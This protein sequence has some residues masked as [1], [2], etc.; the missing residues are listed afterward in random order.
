MLIALYNS[1]LY[2]TDANVNSLCRE[3]SREIFTPRLIL[4]LTPPPVTGDETRPGRAPAPLLASTAMAGGAG[5]MVDGIKLHNFMVAL[6]KVMA[7]AIAQDDP[8]AGTRDAAYEPGGARHVRFLDASKSTQGRR[9]DRVTK[10]FDRA[11]RAIGKKDYSAAVGTGVANA[12][13]RKGHGALEERYLGLET[14]AF[15][16]ALLRDEGARKKL[17]AAIAEVERSADHVNE[18]VI[19]KRKVNSTY[20]MIDVYRDLF[21]VKHPSRG[22]MLAETKRLVAYLYSEVMTA[23]PEWLDEDQLDNARETTTRAAMADADQRAK[24]ERGDRLY[25]AFSSDVKDECLAE[26]ARR[27]QSFR[28]NSREP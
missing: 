22:S 19:R 7:A 16:E 1:H 14:R 23:G 2:F 27:R 4:T 10:F 20:A 9:F 13:N 15:L 24:T 6:T 25:R 28:A 12:L 8:D 18:C 5:L 21:L 26:C 3:I 17:K 11:R